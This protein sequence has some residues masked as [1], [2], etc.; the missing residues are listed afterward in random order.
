MFVFQ[1]V[2]FFEQNSQKFFKKKYKL[3]FIRAKSSRKTKSI[4]SFLNL[5]LFE[6]HFG[7]AWQC[8]KRKAFCH[9]ARLF[10]NGVSSKRI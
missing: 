2:L 7:A 6:T 1:K 3:H 9:F 8:Q 4:L 5:R 10:L